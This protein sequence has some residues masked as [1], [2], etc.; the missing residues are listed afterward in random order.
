MLSLSLLDKKSKVQ[1][2]MYSK[3]LFLL[4]IIV[5]LSVNICVSI[6]KT[7]GCYLLTSQVLLWRDVFRGTKQG[8]PLIYIL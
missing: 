6:G 8:H 1:P 3:I 4:K 5:Y 7:S 2:N